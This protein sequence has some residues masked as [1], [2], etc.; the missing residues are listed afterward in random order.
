MAD[1]FDVDPAATAPCICACCG[2]DVEGEP[3]CQ[4]PECPKCGEQGNPACYGA[5][6]GAQGHGLKFTK[7]QLAGQAKRQEQDKTDA[8]QF[9]EQL[10]DEEL[11]RKLLAGCR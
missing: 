8:E 4:C 10:E 5:A 2:H 1:Y 7:A 6:N 11:A 9:H 3:G